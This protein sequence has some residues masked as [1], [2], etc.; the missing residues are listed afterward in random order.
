MVPYQQNSLNFVYSKIGNP[1]PFTI[2]G[3]NETNIM[4][5]FD[6]WDL[7]YK[8]HSFMLRNLSTFGA[9]VKFQVSKVKFRHASEYIGAYYG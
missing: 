3:P 1:F 8:N 7:D 9:V 5:K 2:V 4:S 6:F